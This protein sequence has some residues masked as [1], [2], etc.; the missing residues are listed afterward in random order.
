[1]LHITPQERGVLK[2]LAR[3]VTPAEIAR[4][5][6][7]DEAAVDACLHSLVARLGVTTRTEAVVAAERRGLFVM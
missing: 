6:G 2:E 3:G 1:M 5:L 7:V 4:R